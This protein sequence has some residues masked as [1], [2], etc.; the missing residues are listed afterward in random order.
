MRSPY[1]DRK[2]SDMKKIELNG[3]WNIDY[4]STEPY[5]SDIEPRFTVSNTGNA[6]WDVECVA[7]C[8]VPGYFEDMLDIFRS[9]PMHTKLAW[10]PLYTLQRYPQTGYCPDMALPNPVG[11]FGYERSFTLSDP[12]EFKYAELYVGGAQNRLSAWING[13]YLGTH[14]GYS[15]EFFM[16]IPA[17]ALKEG[18]NRITLAVSNNRLAGYKDRPVSGLTS[19]AANE[20]TG[21]IWGDVE[22]R[23]YSEGL[24]D[25]YVS[26]AKDL[27]EFTVKTKGAEN[28][29]KRVEI[30]RE[31]EFLLSVDIP[32]GSLDITIPSD[33]FDLWSPKD[34]VLYD[35]KVT[36][37]EDLAECRFGIRRLTSRGMRLYFNGEPYFFRGI[38]EHCY[39]PITVHPTR[40][41][42]YYRRL[43]RTIKELGFNSIR[44]HTHVP[45]PEYMEAADEL[46]IVIEVETPNN[47]T[48][49]E[50]LEIVNASRRHP[51][52][53]AFSSGN[54]MVIDED[55]IEH[56]RAVAAYVHA[57]SDA[58]FSPMSAMRGIEYHSFGDL[59]V[60]EPFP[61]NP[62]RL[63]A[64]D[65]FCDLYNS[66][67]N[68]Q[69][70]YCSSD[71]DPAEIDRKNS[72]YSRP[73]LT[74]EI[75][76]H[77][78]YIDLSL[79]DRYR[80][81]RIGD[82]EFMS[83]VEKH[84]EDAGL[85]DRA[86]LYYRNSVQ[87]QM[88]LRKHCFET[89][90]RSDTFAGYD[91][92]GDIDTHWHTFGYC[93]GMMNEFYELKPGETREN[94]LRY[95]SD[96]VLLCDLPKVPNYNSGDKV[97][98]PILVS[99]Y[100]EALDSATLCVRVNALGKVI[101]RREIRTGEIKAGSITE[102]YTA[103][104]NIPR[105]DKPVKLTVTAT[106]SGGN[107]DAENT[108]DIFAF[109]KNDSPS[110]RA[111]KAKGIT[112]AEDMSITELSER[113]QKGESVVLFGA[114]PFKTAPVTFQLSVAGRTFGH[115]AT[116]VSDHP[117]M[118]N[119]PHDGF[120]AMQFRG[121]MT[122]AKSAILD[123]R[124][125]PHDPIIDIASSYKNAHREAMLFEYRIGAGK[126]LVST[127]AMSD[128]DPAAA[129]LK[130]EMLNYA[131]STDFSP[132]YYISIPTL[133][134]LSGCS[135]STST[136]S[137]S[138]TNQAFNKNDV[139]M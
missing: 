5:K 62:K 136:D 116:V 90:R 45:M 85:L 37:G 106:L 114:G 4:L 131:Q 12:S 40:E 11:C 10:N 34:P 91:F 55:Y 47:T 108:W 130:A 22:I 8:P 43:I 102:L 6:E 67:S 48:Y 92:L 56:L 76:I 111:L 87:W 15:C 33:G 46:G 49:S 105:T 44:F 2:D 17:D 29:K 107:T 74:H 101:F 26:V 32:A 30:F 64:L 7:E 65:E 39:H 126:L 42:N 122:K 31:G 70:S 110:P 132:K 3:K 25:V 53:C 38:C 51:S 133:I 68:S 59:R 98:L 128:T 134:S 27:S 72:I 95:N 112:V 139:T 61:H 9:T 82:T 86:N 124:G 18:E 81:S 97:T 135:T 28:A 118:R 23:G 50:W 80:G 117:L 35:L 73:L 77:G 21:G 88:M 138:D 137:D 103:E 93:V 78:T 75:C 109:P 120:C 79:K 83:S 113:M 121:M 94:V 41:K 16:P 104:F 84:L 66:Y 129:W 54:E 13:T 100:G 57:E 24:R 69:T 63:A 123:T 127:M 58:L 115:L 52:V 36:A 119:F 96:A 19:R 71:G 99:N 1:G 20:C 125:I 89:V 14:E 60:E